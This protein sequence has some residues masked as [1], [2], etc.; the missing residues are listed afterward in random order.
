MSKVVEVGKDFSDFC[1]NGVVIIDFWANWCGPCRALAPVLEQLAEQFP[2]VKFGKVNVDEYGDLA[3][4]FD[5]SSI[6]NICIFKDG[7]LVDR[8]IGV[9]PREVFESKINAQL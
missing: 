7:V 8:V 1:K 3:V 5:V 6:P 4:S 2:A 9:Q